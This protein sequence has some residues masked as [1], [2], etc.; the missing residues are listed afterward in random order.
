MESYLQHAYAFAN[1]TSTRINPSAL[2]SRAA[3]SGGVNLPE[4]LKAALDDD[5]RIFFV[6]V[7][8]F[9]LE[10][11]FWSLSFFY[12]IVVGQWDAFGLKKYAIPQIQPYPSSKMVKDCL[13]DIVIGHTFIRPLLLFIS[14]PIINRY[15]SFSSELSDLPSALTLV[16]QFLVCMQ[17]DDFLF[18]WIHRLF[19]V[20][21]LY[22]HIHKKHHNFKHTIPIA[23]EWAHPLEELLA[24]TFPTVVRCS[25]RFFGIIL[26]YVFT[27]DMLCNIGRTTNS[28]I[29]RYIILALCIG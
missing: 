8:V 11:T 29:A 17:I 25:A 12:M 9:L 14:F 18:Y 20:G 6:L 4:T 27:Y 13:I 22:K 1:A 21:W 10:I 3:L 5:R 7:S 28:S 2:L 16:W 24:N 19:H 15:L 26:F 23:V